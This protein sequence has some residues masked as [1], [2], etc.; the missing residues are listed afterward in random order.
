MK[1]CLGAALVRLS[2]AGRTTTDAI[3]VIFGW[4]GGPSST[5]VAE[6]CT[7]IHRRSSTLLGSQVVRPRNPRSGRRLGF[8]VGRDPSSNLLSNLG[9]NAWRSPAAGGGGSPVCSMVFSFFARVLS[10]KVK[11]L[12]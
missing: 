9:G 5:S 8:F 3:A 7:W 6:A 2:R 12:F 11:A 4:N 10:V 1:R